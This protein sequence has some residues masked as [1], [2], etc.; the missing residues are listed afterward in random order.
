MTHPTSAVAVLA[1]FLLPVIAPVRA[2]EQYLCVPEMATGFAF[3]KTTKQWQTA[4][5]STGQFVIS[6]SKDGK[7]A[8]G[9]TDI[10]DKG[11]GLPGY[12]DKDFNDAGI[13]FCTTFGGELKFNK[14]NRRFLRVFYYATTP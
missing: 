8:Y 7:A 6:P 9:V 4:K 2:V 10:G 1:F 12:C 5:L 11:E 3:N 13:L 14:V